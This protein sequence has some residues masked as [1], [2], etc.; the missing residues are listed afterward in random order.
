MAKTR[1]VNK[2]SPSDQVLYDSLPANLK[3]VVDGITDPT[4][5]SATIK[6]L[7]AQAAPTTTPAPAGTPTAFTGGT[8]AT[9]QDSFFERAI[10][11]E[12]G[13]DVSLR[14]QQVVPGT[15]TRVGGVGGFVP[16]YF[17]RDVDLLARYTRD[18]V[19]D[20][21]AKMQ[22]AGLLGSKYR[23]G[24]PD[25]ATKKA[26]TELLS[27]A[28]NTNTDWTTALKTASAQPAGNGKLPPKVSNPA[29]ILNVAR[30]VSRQ[31]LGREDATILNEIVTAFQRQQV[32]SQMGQLP[33]RDG[34]RVD[35]PGLEAFAEKK[36]QQ[37][38]GP[39]AEA[40]KF[41]QFADRLFGMAGSGEGIQRDVE[42]EMTGG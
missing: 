31:V 30:Q 27:L 38:A 3:A 14:T 2:L 7:S 40:Y 18:Q 36:I 24:I 19:A 34:V 17:E 29:D 13:R 16:R 10:G 11:V 1:K 41:A 28:N 6:A 20:I 35:T 15:A 9:A 23:I 39:E 8:S 21:Q 37:A 32:R 4:Q 5:K 12:A 26:W 42:L 33:M 22:K 25:P